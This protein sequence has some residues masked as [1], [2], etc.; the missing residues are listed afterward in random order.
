MHTFYLHCVKTL[1]GVWM[2]IGYL[3]CVRWPKLAISTTLFI[4]DEGIRL[5]IGELTCI[6]KLKARLLNCKMVA[7]VISA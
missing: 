6:Q 1:P 2:H 5:K 4:F 3:A 7:G